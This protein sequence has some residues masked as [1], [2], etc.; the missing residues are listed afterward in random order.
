MLKPSDVED[1]LQLHRDRRFELLVGARRRLPVGSP[2]LEARGVTEAVSLQML[3]RD[4][5]DEVEAQRLPGEVLARVPPALRAG[6]TLSRRLGFGIGF[7][8]RAPGVVL[9]R[10]LAVRFEVGEELGARRCREAARE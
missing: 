10:P 8:P 3:V 9:E 7:G 2:A 5:G 4:L 6:P 1:G